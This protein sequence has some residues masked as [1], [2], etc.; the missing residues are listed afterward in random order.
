VAG[1]GLDEPGFVGQH[2]HLD[3]VPQPEFGQDA[4]D[5]GLHR[6]LGYEQGG[7]DLR[8][9]GQ[10][11]AENSIMLSFVVAYRQRTGCRAALRLVLV[12]SLQVRTHASGASSDLRMSRADRISSCGMSRIRLGLYIIYRGAPGRAVAA[13]TAMHLAIAL[14]A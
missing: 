1:A 8:A 2:H 10:G 6:R 13:L 3:A 11:C 12:S 7:G 14:I 4:P 5:M 9:A